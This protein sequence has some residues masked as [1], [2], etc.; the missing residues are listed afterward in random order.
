MR[1]DWKLTVT[2]TTSGKSNGEELQKDQVSENDKKKNIWK[3]EINEKE[4]QTRGG[5]EKG[6]KERQTQSNWIRSK[7]RLD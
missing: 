3:Q 1:D 6:R 4:K 5:K 2:T 7:L